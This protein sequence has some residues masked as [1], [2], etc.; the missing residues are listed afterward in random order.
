MPSEYEARR[1]D[2]K[3]LGRYALRFIS[4]LCDAAGPPGWN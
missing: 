3:R 1:G 2:N 4:F